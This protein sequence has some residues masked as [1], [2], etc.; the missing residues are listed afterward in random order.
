MDR[1]LLRWLCTEDVNGKAAGKGFASWRDRM[2]EQ[3]KE[4]EGNEN[5]WWRKSTFPELT[6]KVPNNF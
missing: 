4:E 3:M 5:E 2:I 6:I 1:D